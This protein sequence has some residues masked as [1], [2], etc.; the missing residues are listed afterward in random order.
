MNKVISVLAAPSASAY[1]FFSGIFTSIAT[2]LLTGDSKSTPAKYDLF[3]IGSFTVGHM[4]SMRILF[5]LAMG[6]ALFWLGYLRENAAR[7]ADFIRGDLTSEGEYMLIVRSGLNRDRRSL[8]IAAVVFLIG[9]V[10]AAN[11]TYVV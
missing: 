2:N 8:Y 1:I 4:L 5:L 7:K 6:A 9:V 10:G 3:G 11:I